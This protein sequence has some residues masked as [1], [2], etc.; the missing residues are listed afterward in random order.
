VP[1]D[2]ASGRS[3]AAVIAILTFLAAL[4]AS[5]AELVATSSADWRASAA[6][7]ATI[8]IRPTPGR[9]SDA[10]VVRA[11]E[12]ARASTGISEARPFSKEESERLLEPWLGSGL[13][14]GGIPVPRLIVLRLAPEG[15]G[16]PDMQALRAKL[17]EAVPGASLDDH[18]V[19]MARLSTMA[20]TVVGIGVALAVLVLVATGLAVAFATRGAMAGNREVVDVLH[21]V[22]ANDD[23]IAREFQRRF[24]RLGLRGGIAGAGAALALIV[25]LGEV[26]RLW[27]ASPA[28]DQLQALFGTFDIGWGG[29]L[30]IVV[31]GG[32]VS[33]VTAVVS[34][35]TVRR[36][37]AGTL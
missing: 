8:Q 30:S 1:T 28:G 18:K 20:G 22:G 7:E 6:R 5:G 36:Y 3:L 15:Q 31:I 2:S 35:V 19:W 26:A 11:V 21:F 25:I 9:D 4:C 17:A 27:Q 12:L 13:D 37:L 14:L 32:L 33:V 24:F 34:R 10:D 23:F 16:R 29:V